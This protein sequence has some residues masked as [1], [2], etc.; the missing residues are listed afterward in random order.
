[1]TWMVRRR[2]SKRR[3]RSGAAMIRSNAVETLKKVSLR[4]VGS[5][6]S[7]DGS[8]NRTPAAV[9]SP[10]R[11]RRAAYFIPRTVVSTCPHDPRPHCYRAY[12]RRRAKVSRV[13][14]T[15]FSTTGG[16]LRI[17]RSGRDGLFPCTKEGRG[18]SQRPSIGKLEKAEL[19]RSRRDGRRDR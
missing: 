10:Y 19:C 13:T 18:R 17:G 2:K 8:A 4:L 16:H 6:G 9:G 15:H 5:S 14:A 3:L 12:T 7:E 1:M 11:V